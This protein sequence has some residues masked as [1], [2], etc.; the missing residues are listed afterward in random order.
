MKLNPIFSDHAVFAANKR[1]SIFG[2]GR[3]RATL[4]LG[5]FSI[6]IRS[7]A[8]T[9]CIELPKMD[10]GGPYTLR[11]SSDEEKKELCDIYIGEVLLFSGQS[12]MS[13]TLTDT[14]TPKEYYSESLPLLRYTKIA[15]AG[16][17]VPWCTADEADVKGWSALGYIAG[18][19]C[20]IKKGVAIGVICCAQGASV[21]E[22]WMPEG[23][24][25]G[26]GICL[27]EKEKFLDHYHEEYGKWNSDAFLY[28]HWLKRMIPYTLSGVV[29]YQGESDASPAEGA[30]YLRELEA[31]IRVW[32][33]SFKNPE[34][35]FVIVQLADT[36]S[37][38]E[39]GEGWNLIQRAQEEISSLVPGVYTVISRDISETDDIHPP[40]KHAL[41]CRIAETILENVI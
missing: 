12:N 16:V 4:R 41:G 31:L 35:P 11:F 40:S 15:D 14:N 18:K 7:D 21:I 24:L 17:T 37:R 5:D 32:R 25:E 39:L 36:K 38:I 1:I 29:W 22:S 19:E 33:R 2:S 13:C 26:I 8:D 6:D 28:N 10:Y 34:L 27:P 9:W 20:L 30:L 23:T 3:G